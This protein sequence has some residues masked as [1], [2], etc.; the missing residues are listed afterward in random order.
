MAMSGSIH[1]TNVE[2][3]F[4]TLRDSTRLRNTKKSASCDSI[5]LLL[6]IP[7]TTANRRKTSPS[8]IFDYWTQHKRK[9]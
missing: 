6:S 9:R 8:Q 1:L 7:K 3:F 4:I 2:S 5:T